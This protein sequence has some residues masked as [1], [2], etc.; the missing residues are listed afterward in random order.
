MQFV[1]AGGRNCAFIG[2][3]FGA[4]GR[5]REREFCPRWNGDDDDDEMARFLI[6]VLL[7][8]EEFLCAWFCEVSS[9]PGLH[10]G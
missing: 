8:C 1:T 7:L 5:E 4:R 6:L 3:G 9:C 10:V 2:F